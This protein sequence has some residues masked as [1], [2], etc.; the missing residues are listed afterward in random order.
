MNV[1]VEP[2]FYVFRII[3]V[4]KFCTVVYKCMLDLKLCLIHQAID[5]YITVPYTYQLGG[6]GGGGGGNIGAFDEI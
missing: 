2:V 4:I 1:I 5:V 3:E 6:G